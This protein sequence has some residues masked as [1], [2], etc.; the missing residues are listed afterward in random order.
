MRRAGFHLVLCAAVLCCL[1]ASAATNRTLSVEERVDLSEEIVVGRVVDSMTEWQGKLIVTVSTVEVS[2]TIKGRT[3]G[4]VEVTQLGG[5]AAHP[6]SGISVTMTAS[7]HVALAA[8]E[9]VLLFL[10]RRGSGPLQLV[11]AQAGKYVV[12]PNP[13]TGLRELPVGPKVLD[14]TRGDRQDAVRAESISLDTMRRRIRTHMGESPGL[15][16]G[17]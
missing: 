12:R 2:E 6:D 10:G 13:L 4:T 15:G 3:A 9:E 14:T 17:R 16:V 5:T 8:G 1:T 11:G 7:S